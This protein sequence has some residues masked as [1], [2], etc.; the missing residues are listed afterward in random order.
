M[1]RLLELSEL[2]LVSVLLA[3]VV[4]AWPTTISLNKLLA[5]ADDVGGSAAASAGAAP[6]TAAWGGS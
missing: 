4:S 1:S 3:D 2:V 5:G 6:G